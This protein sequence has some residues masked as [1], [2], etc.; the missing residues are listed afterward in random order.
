R[1]HGPNLVHLGVDLVQ[2]GLHVRYAV[3]PLFRECV[4]SVLVFGAAGLLRGFVS[5]LGAA[6]LSLELFLIRGAAP[7][8]VGQAIGSV[9]PLESLNLGLLRAVE[10]G[11]LP[12]LLVAVRLSLG[13]GPRLLVLRFLDLV[14]V[15]LGDLL[16]PLLV[17]LLRPRAAVFLQRVAVGQIL[18]EGVV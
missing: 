11:D 17:F 14:V 2:D 13:D 3:A 4:P 6:R 10:L 9:V 8:I 18:F 16:L 7:L 1:P 5:L 12:N 15:A